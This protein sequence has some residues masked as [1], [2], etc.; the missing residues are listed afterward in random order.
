MTCI[1]EDRSLRLLDS[2]YIEY[3][4][5]KYIDICLNSKVTIYCKAM[6]Y[7]SRG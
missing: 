7:G 6:K 2:E 5:C 4:D 3:I 1:Q